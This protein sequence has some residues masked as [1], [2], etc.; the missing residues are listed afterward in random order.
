MTRGRPCGDEKIS[1]LP[2]PTGPD[3]FGA[4]SRMKAVSLSHTLSPAIPLWPGDP[5][6]EFEDWA[7]IDPDGYYLRRF[8]MSEHAGTHVSAPASFHHGGKTVDEY[9][10]R[11]LV[12]PAVV[13]DVR[14]QCSR[15]RDY[16]L[17]VDDFLEWESRHG[18][19]P[20]GSL[21]LLLTGWSNRWNDPATYLGGDGSGAL[22]FP[23]FG[24]DA[25]AL[26]VHERRVSGLGT[27]TA[28]VEPGVDTAFTVSRMALARNLIVL[29]NLANLD[30][31]PPTGA[32]LVIGLLRLEG[33]SGSPAAVT[34][35]VP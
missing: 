23:G 30:S 22:H 4:F 21:A 28:G 11:D 1:N 12:Q 6:V 7:A 26:L 33:G 13:I 3:L 2:H 29:Q 10:V 19:A 14:Q 35:F 8:S 27:D 25:A 34:A 5:P 31:L 20:S 15:D 17:T 32:V 24:P 9:E 18:E 16:A